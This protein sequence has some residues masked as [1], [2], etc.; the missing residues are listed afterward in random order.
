MALGGQTKKITMNQDSSS[1]D[2]ENGTNLS[3]IWKAEQKSVRQRKSD[4]EIEYCNISRGKESIKKQKSQELG[5]KKGSRA[6]VYG[7]ILNDNKE[8]GKGQMLTQMLVRTYEYQKYS[9]L[10]EVEGLAI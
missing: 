6:Q 1:E 3:I 10:C 7:S 9:S 5:S 2:G 4:R 8:S